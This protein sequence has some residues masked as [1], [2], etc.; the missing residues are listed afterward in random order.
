MIPGLAVDYC[1]VE[2]DETN[3]NEDTEYDI[4]FVYCLFFREE[5]AHH[6]SCQS[7]RDR[8]G[9]SEQQEEDVR[10]I[11]LGLLCAPDP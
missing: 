9:G 5:L 8:L 10:E 6:K 11:D 3:S 7:E 4:F 2:N 1:R